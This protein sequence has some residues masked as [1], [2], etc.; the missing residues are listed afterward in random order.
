M[1]RR[2][3]FPALVFLILAA[4]VATT[5][6]SSAVAPD[7]SSASGQGEFAFF[8]G[9]STE[10]W[11]Y[12][13]DVSANKHGQARGRAIFDITGNSTQTQVVV[14]VNCLNVFGSTGLAEALMTG[15]VLHSDDPD[16]AKGENVIFAAVDNSGFPTPL[17]DLITPIF[18]FEGDC[19][20][21]ASPLTLFQQ[22]PD[23]IHVEQ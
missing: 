13:F 17:A 22:S 20:E 21:G 6:S 1:K 14:R 19:H 3:T 10:Q 11:S 4:I 23:A 18:V 5:Q 7:G 15:T 2:I 8:N 9:S 16:Y 12:S